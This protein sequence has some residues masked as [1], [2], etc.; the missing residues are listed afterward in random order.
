MTEITYESYEGIAE[1][2]LDSIDEYDDTTCVACIAKGAH[3][4]AIVSALI[5]AD[6]YIGAI[7]IDPDY[8]G[9]YL[10]IVDSDYALYCDPLDVDCDKFDADIV[11][12][13][14]DCNMR[15]LQCSTYWDIPVVAFDMEWDVD[16][17]EDECDCCECC[18]CCE[19]DEYIT[20]AVDDD[21]NVIGFEYEL[22]DEY[23]VH[24]YSYFN[25]DS[26]AVF[27]ELEKFLDGLQ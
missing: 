2:I 9:E 24:K 27:D 11:F 13:H 23:G 14:G 18:D 15:A 8:D 17:D 10:I 21:D 16:D 25:T 6:A 19:D 20:L 7:N 1:D 4:R 26:E 5:S 3:L 22:E 12:I